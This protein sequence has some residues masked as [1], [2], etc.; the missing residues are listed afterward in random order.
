MKGL[1]AIGSRMKMAALSLLG[2]DGDHNLKGAR[3]ALEALRLPSLRG[4]GRQYATTPG[5]RQRK[6]R[7]RERQMRGGG[8]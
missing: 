6:R 4:G 2:R 7:R 8:K 1:S 5:T 3:K